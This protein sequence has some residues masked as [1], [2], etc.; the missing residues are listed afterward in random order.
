MNFKRYIEASDTW[1]DSHY[2]MGTDTDTLTTLPAVLYP[3]AATATVGLSGNTV[4]N[5]TPTPQNPITPQETGERTGNLFDKSQ[6]STVGF[7]REDGTIN[8]NKNYRISDYIQLLPNTQYTVSNMN[9]NGLYPAICFYTD[10]KTYISGSKYDGATVFTFTTP[11]NCKYVLVSY[12]L[13]LVNNVM[14]NTGST[15]LPYEPYGIKIPISSASTTTPVYLGEVQSTR[16]IK[17]LV[18]DGTEEWIIPSSLSGTHIYRLS[19]GGYMRVNANIP[20]CTHYT[21]IAPILGTDFIGDRQVAFLLSSSG[22]NYFYVR[23]DS[24]TTMADFKSYLAQQYAAGTPVCVWY[25]LANPETTVVN[26]PLMKIGDFADEVANVSIPVTAGG[27]TISVDTTLQPSEVSVN[28]KGW[29]PAIVHER[30]NGA[31]T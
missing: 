31:W 5:G 2:I 13:S 27:D 11:S 10:N 9:V 18:L 24:I 17:K 21:G 16:R 23:D 7:V 6:P 20:F 12:L 4:Q 25:V 30:T 15:P 14:L 3:N 19:I 1:V 8:E 28:Y 26:E 29:H 22:N